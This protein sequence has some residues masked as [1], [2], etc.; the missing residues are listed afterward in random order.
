MTKGRATRKGKPVGNYGKFIHGGNSMQDASKVICLIPQR[1]M[2]AISYKN[3][4]TNRD[5]EFLRL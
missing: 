2:V 5:Y 4:N 3:P 1:K